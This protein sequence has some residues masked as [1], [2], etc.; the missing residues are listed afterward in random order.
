M[1]PRQ[2]AI[3]TYRYLRVGI[4]ALAVLLALAV[5]GEIVFGD[6]L[7]GSISAYYFTPARDVFVGVLVALGLGLIV[8]RGRGAEDVLLNLAGMLAPVVAFVP[9]PVTD[10]TLAA[11]G[12][13]PAPTAHAMWALIA[14]GVP[15]LLFAIATARRLD[16]DARV[17][18]LRGTAAG[19]ATIA[20]FGVWLAIDTASFLQAAHYVAAV[21]MFGVFVVVAR[22]NAASARDDPAGPVL[23]MF[24]VERRR[25]GYSLISWS[26]LVAV[27]VAGL[28]GL[29][30]L[31]GHIPI[32]HWLFWVEAILLALFAAFWALQT[33]EYW[34]DGVP[35]D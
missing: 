5:A 15:A 19:A 32:P 4:V 27:V 14:L 6:G 23:A 13:T 22:M 1:E 9:T 24:P 12:A 35:L 34:R 25:T 18:A 11:I 26:M 7:L 16:G 20:A 17:A 10:S 28:L 30:Q 31:A 8:I 21:G 3:E 2:A 29:L 33:I